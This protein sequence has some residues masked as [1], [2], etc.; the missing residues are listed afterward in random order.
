VHLLRE[1]LHRVENG[2]MP[3]AEFEGNGVAGH[4]SAT[5]GRRHAVLGRTKGPSHGALELGTNQDS[6]AAGLGRGG[7]HT[8]PIAGGAGT[9]L[10]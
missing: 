9:H 8:N 4:V 10:G 3:G 2:V 5:S 6:D 1:Q 7:C